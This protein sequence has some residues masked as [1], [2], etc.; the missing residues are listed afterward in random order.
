MKG[1]INDS[2]SAKQHITLTI[3]VQAEVNNPVL[4]CEGKPQ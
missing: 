4:L 2:P 1:F 3:A